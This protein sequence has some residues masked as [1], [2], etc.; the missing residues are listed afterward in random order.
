MPTAETD[1]GHEL[2]S[3][4]DFLAGSTTFW[5]LVAIAAVLV[6][7]SFVGGGRRR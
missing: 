1:W 2:Q 3:F 4:V 6:L 7:G 5:V